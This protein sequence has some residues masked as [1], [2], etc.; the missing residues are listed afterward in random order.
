MESRRT[1]GRPNDDVFSCARARDE[2][3]LPH[4]YFGLCAIKLLKSLNIQEAATAG[5]DYLGGHIIDAL[6]S[7]QQTKSNPTDFSSSSVLFWLPRAPLCSI[8]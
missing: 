8:W 2:P 1:D 5:E 4:Y 6:P 7:L 3:G